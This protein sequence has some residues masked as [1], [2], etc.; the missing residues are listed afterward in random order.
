[1]PT[2]TTDPKRRALG[3]GLESLLPKKLHPRL[4]QQ[5]LFPRL[6]LRLHPNPRASHSKSHSMT[7][8]GIPGRRESTSMKRFWTSWRSRSSLA[9]WCSPYWSDHFLTPT[10]PAGQN[11]RLMPT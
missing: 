8:N 10:Q 9:A 5:R 7:L 3:K 6:L 11:P 4:S 2:A 1:M